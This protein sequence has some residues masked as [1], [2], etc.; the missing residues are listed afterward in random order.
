MNINNEKRKRH[1]GAKKCFALDALK[2]V[3]MV[4]V[5]LQVPVSYAFR[6]MTFNV[7]TIDYVAFNDDD[8]IHKDWDHDGFIQ[9]DGIKT[10]ISSKFYEDNLA[11]RPSEE[12]VIALIKEKKPDIVTFQE[13][14]DYNRCTD[15]NDISKGIR[16]AFET[17]MAD[18]VPQF[19]ERAMENGFPALEKLIEYWKTDPFEDKNGDGKDDD[20]NG[21]GE[22]DDEA[23]I[24]Q[25]INEREEFFREVS[26]RYNF[27]CGQDDIKTH[28]IKRIL[29]DDY[30][31]LWSET[32]PDLAIGVRKDFGRFINHKKSSG[33]DECNVSNTIDG[34]TTC[35]LHDA[36]IQGAE[37]P[38][39]IA[40]I[41]VLPNYIND[42]DITNT[43]VIRVIAA[44]ANAK[45][46]DGMAVRK[47]QF[48]KIFTKGSF[49]NPAP[50]Q[51]P[52]QIDKTN[53]FL[54][55]NSY[56]NNLEYVDYPRTHII[57]GDLNTDDYELCDPG[58]FDNVMISVQQDQPIRVVGGVVSTIAQLA[59]LGLID[60][61][62]SDP[63]AC[64]LQSIINGGLYEPDGPFNIS[65]NEAQTNVPASLK[66]DYILTDAY[67]FFKK[68]TYESRVYPR[69]VG[70]FDH[71]PVLTDISRR[72][73][74]YEYV[75]TTTGA[76]IW[77]AYRGDNPKLK[78]IGAEVVEMRD[79]NGKPIN[80][81]AGKK[82]SVENG[83]WDCEFLADFTDNSN[84]NVDHF[85]KYYMVVKYW[86]ESEYSL[87]PIE[88]TLYE[89]ETEELWS[90]AQL[91][92]SENQR[93]EARAKVVGD[94]FYAINTVNDRGEILGIAKDDNNKV[95]SLENV[96]NKYYDNQT[97]GWVKNDIWK[98]V[99]SCHEGVPDRPVAP[100]IEIKTMN[101]NDSNCQWTFAGSAASRNS[102]PITDVDISLSN[103]IAIGG[104]KICEG[105]TQW[106]CQ[107]EVCPVD[108]DSVSSEIN[109]EFFQHYALI[110]AN[111]E[112]GMTTTASEK[113]VIA[114]PSITIDTVQISDARIEVAGIAEDADGDLKSISARMVNK[115]A[116][117]VIDMNCDGLYDWNCF[118]DRDLLPGEYELVINATDTKGNAV[119]KKVEFEIPDLSSITI[120]QNGSDLNISGKN[121]D[122]YDEISVEFN[123]K[124]V[125]CDGESLWSCDFDLSSID[126]PGGYEVV[127][128]A[129]S[130]GIVQTYTVL[131][132]IDVD[133]I[134]VKVGSI[135]IIVPKAKLV[136]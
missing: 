98:K 101:Y 97:G 5:V 89:C 68:D 16:H 32:Y 4:F 2:Y 28:Q 56:D 132:D 67:D 11:W 130:A 72:F 27:V 136:Q 114:P 38:G 90:H 41:D 52:N 88:F 70:N 24:Q 84:P 119:S 17:G 34:E 107:V 104:K 92:V 49:E 44:H 48:Q 135:P 96:A 117:Y 91:G 6:A 9:N 75:T 134:P 3:L 15:W 125:I 109:P 111:T 74:H 113:L 87:H 106:M 31:Y 78:I 116:M 131:L 82:C 120:N 23:E 63:S 14:Y 102:S 22:Y 59:S 42:P 83:T 118:I 133:Y 64:A 112:D 85:G 21:D 53:M 69:P 115:S 128:T 39:R 129:Y 110:S 29:G 33:K 26:K 10:K 60:M 37:T 73:S 19:N 61:N 12:S 40:Y 45:F 43:D 50:I 13:L 76:R 66:F 55:S 93:F 77:G 123:G 100:K 108:L 122:S 121:A 79:P 94:H 36:N 86:S 1:F 80:H 8:S 25:K 54:K 46:S 20:V 126:E 105:T 51:Y 57:L 62:F 95:V 30:H 99:P 124:A 7:G 65:T 58:P 18:L 127:L 103:V 47:Q 81:I 71:K 35:F